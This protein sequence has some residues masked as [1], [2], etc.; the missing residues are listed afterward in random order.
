MMSP[1]A[2][3]GAGLATAAVVTSLV[4]VSA[5]SA[6][7]KGSLVLAISTDMQTP[8]DLDVISIFVREGNVVKFDYLG[9]VVPIGTVALPATIAVV[10]PDDPSTAIDI[11]II[12]FNE[13]TAR[14][15]RDI[16]TS[17]PHQRTG[18][19]RVPLDFI[20]VD[21]GTGTIPDKYFPS[22]ATGVSEGLS[23]F[24][25]T[26]IAST[27][28]P[29]GLCQMPGADCQTTVNGG[30]ASAFVDPGT[31]ATYL[32]QE[33]FG[34]GGFT[35]AGTPESC[36]DV[37][38][39]FAGAM[40]VTTVTALECQFPFPAGGNPSTFNVGLMTP[41]SGACVGVDQCYVPLPEDPNE[42]W[43]LQGSTVVLAPGVC[44]H[45]GTG[46]TVVVSAGACPADTLSQP[47][48]EPIGPD[49][50]TSAPGAETPESGAPDAA[51]MEAASE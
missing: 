25:P 51:E 18:L 29:S 21:S 47:V 19:L 34:D 42:G 2:R 32:P 37:E 35:A 45:V 24:D 9:H 38:T 33:V 16:Q 27:C 20:D 12:G 41:A 39:C 36:F 22:P 8:K 48:C 17:V 50:S 49:A 26:A 46:V 1:S 44:S 14:V 13:R 15:L 5:C 3:Y 6:A 4:G 10:E 30:C 40:P 31:L 43:S 28:D 11:R 23:Q 7:S